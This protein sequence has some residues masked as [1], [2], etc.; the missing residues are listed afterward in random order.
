[1]TNPYATLPESILAQ[2]RLATEREE[3]DF[4]K[5]SA[6]LTIRLLQ[7]ALTASWDWAVIDENGRQ[8]CGDALS[9]F[10]AL[11]QALNEAHRQGAVVTSVEW[12]REQ[13]DWADELSRI[14]VI[15]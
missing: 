2:N 7:R 15:A 13:V 8:W 4:R 9:E 1:M 5:G 11:R 6:A 14:E 12:L 3:E 10:E